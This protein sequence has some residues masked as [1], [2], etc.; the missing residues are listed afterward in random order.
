MKVF[1][2]LVFEPVYYNVAVLHI[3][4]SSSISRDIFWQN[5]HRTRITTYLNYRWDL[6][7]YS[8]SSTIRYLTRFSILTNV[9]SIELLTAPLRYP[10]NIVTVIENEHYNSCSYPRRN[11]LHFTY[12][13][14]L[15]KG[16]NPIILPSAMSQYYG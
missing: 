12:P 2:R 7:R 1:A 3:S 9:L 5:S 11:C 16:R 15:R 6:D 14:T 4:H 10:C 8:Y 13:T